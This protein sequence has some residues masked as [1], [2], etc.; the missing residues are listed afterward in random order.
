MVDNRK[1]MY[2]QME[3]E[4]TLRASIILPGRSNKN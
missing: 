1:Y 2:N 3:R 4:I